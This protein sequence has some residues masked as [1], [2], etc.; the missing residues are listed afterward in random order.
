MR[1]PSRPAA[2][3]PKQIS[4]GWKAVG[5]WSSRRRQQADQ[6]FTSGSGARANPLDDDRHQVNGGH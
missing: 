3:T 2:E 1:R 6:S 5:S 4:V